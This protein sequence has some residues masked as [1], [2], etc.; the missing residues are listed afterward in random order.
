MK[1]V[2]RW[3]RDLP[4]QF[5]GKRNIE[6]LIK[7]FARQL[8]E[9]QEVFDELN[10]QLDLETAV[11]KNLDYVGTILP[12]SRKE[13]GELAGI[14]AT[15]PVI[16]DERY[17]RFMKY[18][19]LQN[20]S[21]CTYYDLVSGIELLWGY[22]NICYKEDP[23]HPAMIV[24]E[25]PMFSLD[26]VDPVEFHAN[27]CIR[28][29]G[30]G[31]FLRKNYWDFFKV[32]TG[33][34][35][36][37]T[38]ITAFYPRF[39]TPE[40][41]LDNTWILE[42]KRELSGYDGGE[43]MDFYPVCIGFETKVFANLKEHS[44]VCLLLHAEQMVKSCE[45]MAVKASAEWTIA[46]TQTM[47]IQAEAAGMPKEEM[48][49]WFTTDAREPI[50]SGQ[51]TSFQLSA[52]CRETIRECMALRHTAEVDA[53]AGDILIE[54]RNMLDDSWFFDGSRELNGGNDMR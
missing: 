38:F 27:L 50:E 52:E 40:L 44:Q 8:Q 36:S 6:V 32:E 37:I 47:E 33:Q 42:G 24:F 28:A 23:K 4:Q 20:T 12:L 18:K 3:L 21:E 51:T 2:D 53:G 35:L 7:A 48:K 5:L 39:N 26:E 17:R 13:A 1:I 41:L 25:T 45:I 29:S 11:G 30:I 54:T 46:S 19:I 14:G 43:R 34:S 49:V 9:L 10:T 15:E 31:V 22:K 16:S